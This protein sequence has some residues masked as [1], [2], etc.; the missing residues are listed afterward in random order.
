MRLIERLGAP[1]RHRRA[2]RTDAHHQRQPARAAMP[3]ELARRRR[4]AHQRLARHARPGEVPRASRAGATSTRCCDG[5]DAAQDGRP[6]RS[7]STRWRCAASTTT[8]FDELIAWAHGRGMDLTFIEVM[9]MGEIGDDARLDQY[10][11]L[12]MVRAEL[13]ATLHAERQRLSHRRP[14]ALLRGRGDRRPARLHH[15]AHPQFLR[16]LQPRAR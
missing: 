8:R 16:E 15:A 10:L 5:I 13:D 12:S 4:E 3:S 9:P 14:G 1:S 7:R 6:R 11:P 2:R